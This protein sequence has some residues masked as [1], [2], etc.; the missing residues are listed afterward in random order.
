MEGSEFSSSH[1]WVWLHLRSNASSL[2]KIMSGRVL[3]GGK[4][5]NAGKLSDEKILVVLANLLS[6]GLPDVLCITAELIGD[7][8]IGG[9][10]EAI[11]VAELFSRISQLAKA[12]QWGSARKFT[13]AVMVDYCEAD[14]D[15]LSETLCTRPIRSSAERRIAMMLDSELMENLCKPVTVGPKWTTVSLSQDEPSST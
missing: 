13:A 3:R 4:K 6:G 7:R 10:K 15:L 8:F 14:V 12:G 2:L 11:F 9:V 5:L 1:N